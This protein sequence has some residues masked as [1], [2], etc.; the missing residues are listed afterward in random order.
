VGKKAVKVTAPGPAADPTVEQLMRDIRKDYGKRMPSR[1]ADL[2]TAR[3]K[4]LVAVTRAQ[5]EIFTPS[6]PF[7]PESTD[8]GR[9]GGSPDLHQA[10]A[11]MNRLMFSDQAWRIAALMAVAGMGGEDWWAWVNLYFATPP[12]ERATLL[13]AVSLPATIF[14][15]MVL[16]SVL[17]QTAREGLRPHL[18]LLSVAAD[19]AKFPA[20]PAGTRGGLWALAIPDDVSLDELTLY[21]FDGHA[22]RSLASVLAAEVTMSARATDQLRWC[23]APSCPVSEHSC[24][25]NA[26]STGSGPLY[27]DRARRPDR[28]SIGCCEAHTLAA[29]R[30]VK[31]SRSAEDSAGPETARKTITM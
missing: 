29:N 21:S 23:Q 25:R 10:L 19:G 1:Q 24:T 27:L 26:S 12:S 31:R 9:L 2:L 22:A 28:P 4:Q 7:V 16:Y 6:T 17:Q 5:A 3:M 13:D 8:T 20:S 18:H 14:E 15:P 30:A 11:K